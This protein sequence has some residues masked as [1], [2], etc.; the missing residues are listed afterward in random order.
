MAVCRGCA[1]VMEEVREMFI[2]RI[3]FIC[4]H[5]YLEAGEC[6]CYPP[7][8]AVCR[9]CAAVMEEVMSDV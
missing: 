9:D 1:A 5:I 4:I 7:A 6:F 3:M 8:M 2:F